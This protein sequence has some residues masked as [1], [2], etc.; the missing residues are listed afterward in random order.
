M[1]TIR[2]RMIDRV[3]A[4]GR[5]TDKVDQRGQQNDK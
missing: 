2:R 5:Q 4:S 3:Q 1:M